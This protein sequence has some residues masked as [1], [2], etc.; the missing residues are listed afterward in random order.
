MAVSSSMP[1]PSTRGLW[2]TAPSSRPIRPRS[3]KCWS[4]MTFR[5]SPSP[6]AMWRS[7]DPVGLAARALDQHGVAHHGRAGRGA[8]EHAPAGVDVSD[9]LFDGRVADLAGDAQL[10]SSGEENSARPLEG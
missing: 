1:I 2:A 3:A 9:A 4:M 5:T 8:G 10:V 7:P 6:G